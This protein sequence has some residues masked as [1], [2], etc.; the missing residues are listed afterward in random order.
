MSLQIRLQ[1]TERQRTR[2]AGWILGVAAALAILIASALW[3]R[4]DGQW[5]L[6]ADALRHQPWVHGVTVGPGGETRGESWFSGT[7]PIIAYQTKTQSGYLD[8]ALKVFSRYDRDAKRVSRLPAGRT[9]LEAPSDSILYQYILNEK[10]G[11][12]IPL[13]DFELIRRTRTDVV[14]GDRRRLDFD[15][16]FR[17]VDQP[18]V[19]PRVRIRVDPETHL[20][21]SWRTLSAEGWSTT[22]V[23][24]P[25]GGPADIYSLGVPL[26]AEVT[27]Q[28]PANSPK[29]VLAGM[30]R[31]RTRFDDYCGFVVGDGRNVHRVW[32][33]GKKWR[34]DRLLPGRD[35]WPTPHDADTAWWKAHQTDYV[36]TTAAIC[37]GETI[38]YYQ[39]RD[40]IWDSDI[41]AP[42]PI[43]PNGEQPVAGP[44][45][46]PIVP[47]PYLMPE[48][49]GHPSI[50]LPS[51]VRA[52]FL[53]SNPEDGPGGSI[54][55]RVRDS[56][57]LKSDRPDVNRFW[58]DPEQ[59]FL[60]LQSESCVSDSADPQTI[61][62]IEASILETLARSPQGHWYPTRVR[63]K[64]SN[65]AVEQITHFYLDFEAKL[66]DELFEPLKLA[67]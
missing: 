49:L 36:F 22:T 39:P 41:T 58:I 51:E 26:D 20:P 44:A 31:G 65:F 11:A 18:E 8:G 60:C 48:Q 45:D 25:D 29:R 42:P 23:D 16:T 1:P 67:E 13:P 7:E 37:D 15:L 17:L 10:D 6:V 24:Y 59:N 19:Q 54:R 21:E 52:L 66:P 62:Y 3:K 43:R 9:W 40:H 53:E 38:H 30:K 5:D 2:R 28:P 47:W 50:W 4:P 64:T 46:D 55:L 34:A 32:K 14:E 63:R 33:K 27:G 61:S 12:A 56:R 35:N 57:S